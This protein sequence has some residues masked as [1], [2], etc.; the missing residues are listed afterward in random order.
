M[1]LASLASLVCSLFFLGCGVDPEPK[2][3]EGEEQAAEVVV[4]FLKAL[5][6]GEFEE[7]ERYLYEKPDYILKDLERCREL[8]FSVKPTG[9]TVLKTG[10]EHYGRQWQAYVDLK[11]NY[12]AQ[13]K[14]LHFTVAPGTPPKL[15]GVNPIID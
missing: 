10:R 1:R 5:E 7:A 9:M 2:S 6:S 11:I 14:K 13:M 3:L 4:G 12:G 15:R 8:F